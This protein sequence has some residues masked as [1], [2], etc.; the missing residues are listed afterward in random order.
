MKRDFVFLLT[1][2]AFLSM[3][4]MT[5]CALSLFHGE[6]SFVEGVHHVDGVNMSL[7]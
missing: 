3:L 7:C 6:A 2:P 1:R 4:L 5:A